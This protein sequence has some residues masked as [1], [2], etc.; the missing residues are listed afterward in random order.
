ML[1]PGFTGAAPPNLFSDFLQNWS[2]FRQNLSS[3][4]A[5]YKNTVKISCKQHENYIKIMYIMLEGKQI[6]Q[7]GET[8]LFTQFA[9]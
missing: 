2:A 8:I 3:S 9:I 6:G 1:K 4:Y 7:L 5:N